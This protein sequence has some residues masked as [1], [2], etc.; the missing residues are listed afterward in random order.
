[1]VEKINIDLACGA[2]KKEG[3]LGVDIADVKGVDVVHNL[4]KYPWPFEDN[5][6][7]EIN[8]SHY[9][10][11]IP[12]ENLRGILEESNSFEEF[13][14]KALE[15]DRDGLIKFMN[16]VYRILK[17]KGRAL[18][19]APHY[20]SIRA[21]GDPTHVRYVGDFSF[22]YFNKDWMEVNKLQ[23]YGIECDFDIKFSYFIS[24]DLSL[25]SEEVQQKAF[26]EDWN[27]IDDIIV[28]MIKK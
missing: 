14:E 16:E 4:T 11:H 15:I 13:K 21:F 27:A 1:M 26:K 10:E 28:Q 3:F 24:N 2:N 19:T 17:P 5:S 22:Y 9:V 7:D 6:V 20:M 8:C 18:I 23:H 12:H 25:K